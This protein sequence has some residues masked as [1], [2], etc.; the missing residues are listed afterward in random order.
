VISVGAIDSNKTVA[1]FSQKNDQ[2][3]LAA[4]GVGVLST[5]PYKEFNSLTVESVT[6][7]GNWIQNAARTN[8][9]SGTLAN[10][11]RCTATNTGWSG[12]VVMCE[13][14]DI[15]F[16]DKVMNVQNSGGVAAVIYN[17]V[18]GNF[19]GT[20]GDGNS[21]TIPAISLS[22]ADGQFIVANKLGLA[23]TVVSRVEKPA[24]GYEE[25]DGTSM[26]T[27][28]VTGV[29]A[30]VW[31]HFPDCTNADIRQALDATAQDLGPAGRDTSYGHGLV[32]AKA[33]FDYLSANPCEP[34]GG[35][36][37]TA[38][39]I[40]NV[41]SQ[42]VNKAGTFDILWSTDIPAT[43]HVLFTC[44]GLYSDYTL[45][46]EHR[47]RFK[48]RKGVLY[49]YWVFS[50]ESPGGEASMSGPHYHQN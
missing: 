38:P 37:G 43:S 50:E 18:S 44:C 2:V 47:M 13:R 9:L 49:E 22:Q 8:G 48:G 6:Y 11:A 3:E 36:G 28:H 12:K 35:G 25:W 10:G 19:R 41:R 15:S 4:P 14:G 31:S 39:V 26:A 21:S 7:Q 33:A 46:T 34:G 30:L 23:G 42:K 27:P 20:L 5:V 1:S 24:S 29:A 40:S 16:F 45:V 32:Q 17:N